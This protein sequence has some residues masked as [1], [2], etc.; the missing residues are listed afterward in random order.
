MEP[1]LT[2][3]IKEPNSYTLDFSLKHG[4]YDGLKKALTMPPNIRAIFTN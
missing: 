2:K 3:Y 1:V 4:A